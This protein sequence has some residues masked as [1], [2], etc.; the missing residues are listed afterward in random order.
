MQIVLFL[1]LYYAYF[2]LR[3][4][5]FEIYI[6]CETGTLELRVSNI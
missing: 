4:Q 1:R 3:I 5:T 2:D 6:I